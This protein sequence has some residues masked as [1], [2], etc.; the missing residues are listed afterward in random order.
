MTQITGHPEDE[1][2]GSSVGEEGGRSGATS[3]RRDPG[4]PARVAALLLTIAALLPVLVV[5]A[6]RTGRAYL[7]VQDLAY[8][9]LRVRDVWSSDIPLVGPY[10]RGFNHPGPLLFWLIG[11]PA[12]L[13]GSPAW[14]TLVG[15]ALLQG[16]AIAGS[17]WVAWR[18]G[19]LRVL[20]VV[21]LALHLSYPGGY[22]FLHHWNPNIAFPFLALYLL[23]LWSVSCGE[24]GALLWAAVVGTFLVHS[25]VGY[26][27]LVGVT[28]TWTAWLVVRGRG[29][30]RPALRSWSGPLRNSAIVTAILWLPVAVEQAIPGRT[31]NLTATWRYFTESEDPS[32]GLRKAAGLF[33]TEFRLP[34]P[35]FGGG[36]PAT[37]LSPGVAGSSLSWLL[38]PSLLAAV[39]VWCHRRNPVPAAARLAGLLGVASVTGVAALAGVKGETFAYLF[40]WRSLLATLLLGSLLL[41]VVSA[42]GLAEHR[43]TWAAIGAVAV[44]LLLAEITG[45]S[46]QVARN[47]V[48]RVLPYEPVAAD[49]VE[50]IEDRG[51]PRGPVLVRGSGL[52]GIM[53]AVLDELDRRGVPMRVDEEW[54]YKW[55]AGR[56]ATPAEVDALWYIVQD[57][58][59]VSDLT[60]R[61][62]ADVLVRSSPLAEDD[63]AELVRLQRGLAPQLRAAGRPELVGYLDASLFPFLVE[64]VEGL[65]KTDVDRLAVLN[66]EVEQAGRCRCAAVAFPPSAADELR[67]EIA[68]YR[69]E[70]PDREAG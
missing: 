44:G 52:G 29:G 11:I 28:G 42:L 10:S 36:E 7:P 58:H 37:V 59:L 49:F 26:L 31:G 32:T 43:Y 18:R 50:R 1:H 16:V 64:D 54:T 68:L 46:L 67:A 62:G 14:A 2:L 19:G 22:M 38:I 70:L 3:G 6:T 65:D 8:I 33:A 40:Q 53:E 20:V 63:E 34:P 24:R 13:L 45:T 12:G 56:G 57:G 27:L 17:A 23:L 41:V 66:E 4:Q 21:L 55:G 25:H 5:V 61:P 15:G 35:W 60:G 39:A 69:T 30:L 48:G 51:L 47:D 9:D